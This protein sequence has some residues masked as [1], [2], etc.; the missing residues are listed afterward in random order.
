MTEFGGV[1]GHAFARGETVTFHGG[2]SQIGKAA[3]VASS[4]GDWF[5]L[6]AKSRAI[7]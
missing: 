6:A 4:G 5:S 7:A 1:R 2:F 3:I